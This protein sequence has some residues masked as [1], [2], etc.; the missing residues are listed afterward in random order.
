MS[1][2]ED[3]LKKLPEKVKAIQPDAKVT[4][5]RLKKKPPKDLDNTVQ[6]FHEEAFEKIDCLA[7]ANCCKTLGPRISDNDINRISKY[8]KIKPGTF[9]DTYLK[10]DEDKDYV[11]K[12]MPCP[13]LMPDNYCMIYEVRPKACKEYPHT[14]RK[15]FYQALNITL[16]NLDTCPAVCEITE[17]LITKYK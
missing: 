4:F 8:L 13:F 16:K 5:K 10:I 9:I 12:N 17:N 15:R 11:F 7:C 1:Y 14:N 6:Q 2:T 3:Y